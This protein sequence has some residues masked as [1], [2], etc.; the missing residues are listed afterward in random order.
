MPSMLLL[1]LVRSA[2]AAPSARN[3]RVRI[4]QRGEMLAIEVESDA[5]KDEAAPGDEIAS[6]RDRIGQLYAKGAQLAIEPGRARLEIPRH[7]PA[8][9][10][11]TA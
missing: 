3:V 8:P 10:A 9:L 5:R 1:P 6:V 4:G 7:A 11:R 2:L